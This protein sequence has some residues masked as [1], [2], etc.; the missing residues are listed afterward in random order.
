MI[1]NQQILYNIVI[2]GS[3]LQNVLQIGEQQMCES[4]IPEQS[5]LNDY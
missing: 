3:R 5:I 2:D 1:K 4:V